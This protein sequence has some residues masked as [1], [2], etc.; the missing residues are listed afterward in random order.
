MSFSDSTPRVA[1]ISNKRRWRSHLSS[2]DK[3][4]PFQ[5]ALS[6]WQILL[7]SGGGGHVCPLETR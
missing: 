5:V 7:I 6:E 2:R 3:V 4:I 1:N